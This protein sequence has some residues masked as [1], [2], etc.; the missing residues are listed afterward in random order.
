MN[1]LDHISKAFL[2]RISKDIFSKSA[3]I[4]NAQV[5]QEIIFLM[6]KKKLLVEEYSILLVPKGWNFYSSNFSII[7]GA[8]SK[9]F[10]TVMLSTS[11][12]LISRYLKNKQFSE[13]N[14]NAQKQV[15]TKRFNTFLRQILHKS[16][17]SETLKFESHN[18]LL[19]IE[20][21]NFQKLEWNY[22]FNIYITV[23]LCL[24]SPSLKLQANFFE[25]QL[26]QESIYTF[27]PTI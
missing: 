21:Q 16:N 12:L 19:A 26:F 1:D 8:I 9:T 13:S 10:K 25:K 17:F 18:L 15:G 5:G 20:H 23:R 27:M 6:V 2:Q 14:E 11:L 24:I 3:R 4:L 7:S 22:N